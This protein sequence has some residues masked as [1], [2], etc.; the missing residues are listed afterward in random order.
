MMGFYAVIW[1]GLAVAIVFA[2]VALI[3]ERRFDSSRDLESD[4]RISM[5]GV[6]DARHRSRN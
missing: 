5:R 1:A 6:E 2:I 3:R 4:R